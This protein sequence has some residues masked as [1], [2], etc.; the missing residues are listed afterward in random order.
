MSTAITKR[1]IGPAMGWMLGLS[2]ALSWIPLFGGLIAGFVGGRKAGNV[3]T[4]LTAVFVPGIVLFLVTIV[5]GALVGWIPIIGTL[6][7]AIAGAGGWML[8][9]MNV[10]PLVIGAAIGG[11]TADKYR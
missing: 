6:W 9:F 11:A 4:A 5:M 1:G 3:P 2:V 10:I 7:G 8:S